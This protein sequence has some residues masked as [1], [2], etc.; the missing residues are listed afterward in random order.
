MSLNAAPTDTLDK[1]IINGEQVVKFDG[2]QLVGKTVSDY[3]VTVA[4][5][6]TADEAVRIHVIRTDGQKIKVIKSSGVVEGF[7]V[8]D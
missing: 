7:R 4:K 8:E 3:K 1:Y 2:S 5:S 6:N